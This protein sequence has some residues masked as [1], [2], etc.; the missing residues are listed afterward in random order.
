MS[1]RC[2]V[3]SSRLKNALDELP[4]K[5]VL[6]PNERVV[7]NDKTVVH[8]FGNS[9]KYF[10]VV[11]ALA[12][13][14]QEAGAVNRFVEEERLLARLYACGLLCRGSRRQ[15][16]HQLSWKP[17]SAAVNLRSLFTSSFPNY[18]RV[19]ASVKVLHQEWDEARDIEAA[20]G[21]DID[22]NSYKDCLFLY[23]SFMRTLFQLK[24][25]RNTRRKEYRIGC[26]DTKI[27]FARADT[28]SLADAQSLENPALTAYWQKRA[29]RLEQSCVGD[30]GCCWIVPWPSTPLQ[31]VRLEY[32]STNTRYPRYDTLTL[33]PIGD[34]TKIWQSRNRNKAKALQ[35][36][37]WGMHARL[38][39]VH[40]EHSA[41]YNVVI[42][43]S[44]MKYFYYLAVHQQLGKPEHRSV[45]EAVFLSALDY[46]C[47]GATPI[48]PCTFANHLAVISR[49]GKAILR[50]RSQTELY[51]RCWE[52]GVGEL[53][54][55]PAQHTDYPHCDAEGKPNLELFL[56][57]T[58]REEF[59][60][61][62]A[63]PEEFSLRGF[64]ME[65]STLAPKLIGIYNSAADADEL[66]DGA[67]N[68]EDCATQ[69]GSVDLNPDAITELLTDTETYPVWT[70]LS[71]L[72]LMLAMTSRASSPTRA[73]AWMK[74]VARNL[75]RRHS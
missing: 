64:A 41:G 9:G 25:N 44:P 24:T 2:G 56:K 8:V 60:L 51:P 72:A 40:K 3:S 35:A 55:G 7:A 66:C 23:R 33:R 62:I 29:R 36:E 49:D 4:K 27:S 5:L 28:A 12:E 15:D 30:V 18:L 37:A 61:D 59:A 73:Q 67:L 68:A 16:T 26:D 47:D 22:A 19:A 14:Q 17:A 11:K 75:D 71:R 54:H 6:L 42:D 34:V 50:E 1:A 43:L 20:G 53:L 63:R 65:Y 13:L 38:E 48:L 58:I 69:S 70:P 31:R 39:R 74:T 10:Q 52:V 57:N 21:L 45:R 46:L 32:D